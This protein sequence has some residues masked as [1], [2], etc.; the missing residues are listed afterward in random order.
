M[1]DLGIA[2]GEATNSCES[3]LDGAVSGQKKRS[4]RAAINAYCK[5]CIYDP[6]FKGGGT[7]REQVQACPVTKCAL[8]EFRPVSK[9]R[10]N[11]NQVELELDTDEE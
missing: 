4:M 3:G 9:P 10:K 7:W 8:Y 1:S 2:I 11:G 5:D 6:V